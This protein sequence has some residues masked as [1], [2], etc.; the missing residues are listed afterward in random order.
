[1]T[2]NFKNIIE[3]L[4]HTLKGSKSLRQD[5]NSENHT[6]GHQNQIGENHYN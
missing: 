2:A 5:K 6:K 3:T 1:M 4:N